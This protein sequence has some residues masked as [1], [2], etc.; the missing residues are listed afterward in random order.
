MLR[1]NSKAALT[2][3]ANRQR[4]S[5]RAFYLTVALISAFAVLSLLADQLAKSRQG[6]QYGVAHVKRALA[7][8]TPLLKRDEEVQETPYLLQIDCS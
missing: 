8:V 2:R 4:Y 1:T 6:A 5:F 7:D 3:R